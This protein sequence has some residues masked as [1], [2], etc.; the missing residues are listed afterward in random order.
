MA[1]SGR[2]GRLPAEAQDLSSTIASM[3]AQYENQRDRN[4]EFAWNHGGK[5]EG[6]KV[7][8]QF[9]INWWQQRRAEVSDDDPM[10]DYYDQ[11]IFNYRFQIREQ[12]VTLAYTQGKLN[13]AG[14]ARF[15]VEEAGKVPRNSAIWR[16]LMTNAAR[17]RKAAAKGRNSG[18]K[19]SSFESFQ[20][21]WN[22]L[23]DTYI[24]PAMTVESIVE[25][26]LTAT[27]T[28]S[29]SQWSQAMGGGEMS[30]V[31]D[32]F[33]KIENDPQYAQQ[34][35]DVWEPALRRADPH[36]FRGN[37]SNEYLA[38]VYGRARNGAKRQSKL[39][40]RRGYSDWKRSA[41]KSAGQWGGRQATQARWDLGTAVEQVWQDALD[42]GLNDQS[43]SPS[44]RMEI[45]AQ[46]LAEL[47]GLRRKAA[48][49]GADTLQGNITR[50]MRILRGDKAAENRSGFSSAVSGNIGDIPDSE[51]N[52]P[53]ARGGSEF[54][55]NMAEQARQD[56]KDNEALLA[57]ESV[58]LEE[59]GTDG[60]VRRT[61]VP[62]G[63]VSSGRG[64]AVEIIKA[65]GSSYRDNEGNEVATPSGA[66]TIVRI[67]QPIRVQV[68]SQENI[69][70]LE[71]QTGAGT[72]AESTS[73]V[74]G[75]LFTRADG[76]KQYQLFREDGTVEWT[77]AP[78]GGNGTEL[79]RPE[80][81][82][83]TTVGSDGTITITVRDTIG[84]TIVQ[85]GTDENGQPTYEGGERPRAALTDVARFG[86]EEVERREGKP[87]PDVAAGRALV[88]QITGLD[89]SEW[90]TQERA[91]FMALSPE[92]RR[93]LIDE[94]I[95][96]S[97]RTG[98]QGGG[99]F[100]RIKPTELTDARITDARD[101][102][103]APDR[104]F[105]G[106]KGPQ[107]TNAPIPA[108]PPDLAEVGVTEAQWTNMV[109]A[110][111]AGKQDAREVMNTYL[112]PEQKNRADQPGRVALGTLEGRL[113]EER[114]ATT[115]EP[116]A[117]RDRWVDPRTRIDELGRNIKALEDRLKDPNVAPQMSSGE[118]ERIQ[119][120]ITEM[121]QAQVRTGLGSRTTRQELAGQ[122]VSTATGVAQFLGTLL[123][124]NGLT[125]GTNRVTVEQPDTYTEYQTLVGGKDPASRKAMAELD[126][127]DIINGL[128]L[129]DP[130]IARDPE[131]LQRLNSEVLAIHRNAD[132]DNATYT[133]DRLQEEGV[134]PE[135][136]DTVA[137]NHPGGKRAP[138]VG[139]GSRGAPN[140]RGVGTSDDLMSADPS[141]PRTA[142]DEA[143]V[144][145]GPFLWGG[146]KGDPT[147]WGG[148]AAFS[149][150]NR[151]RDGDGVSPDA[152]DRPV[153][154]LPMIWGMSN[155]GSVNAQEAE[156]ERHRL[157]EQ[158]VMGSRVTFD[159]RGRKPV[160]PAQGSRVTPEPV[161]KT[162]KPPPEVEPPP[163][164]PK[165]TPAPTPAAKTATN[166]AIGAAVGGIRTARDYGGLSQFSIVNRGARRGRTTG[167]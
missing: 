26:I 143:D 36:H 22:N 48:E 144:P 97:G 85:T 44:E 102:G 147:Q 112:T 107:P 57:G 78:V 23:E 154:K 90:S 96:R 12:K 50:D 109:K 131:R 76:T 33:A 100:D 43:K 114:K 150:V 138:G 133:S 135:V 140:A 55:A 139:G 157:K 42:A 92:N 34:W 70:G 61:V 127:I 1:R 45:R 68:T 126:P 95:V 142:D 27:D 160:N 166:V 134:P 132:K 125:D 91:A 17:F 155:F 71:V 82:R 13:E 88:S 108:I 156:R 62:R 141:D 110:V 93:Y 152:G 74:V 115:Q 72:S 60:T 83:S 14:V 99:G 122:V 64:V 37:L 136:A 158:Q 21:Q 75:F 162:P 137:G 163:K 105:G 4:V 84:G 54:D 167:F 151:G 15:Y 40:D 148:L 79:I 118:K 103:N 19:Q 29:R 39:A 8:D 38:G 106:A 46:A 58:L 25:S 56:Q 35:R 3:I 165:P 59:V 89:T 77:D 66:I 161:M 69:T 101:H 117:Q 51:G 24:K 28:G 111:R 2:F 16:D 18:A 146:G 94:G 53:E 120:S 5:F 73:G 10:A 47:G 63:Q 130:S 124:R 7:T 123:G 11:M 49:L 41:D 87:P 6:K 81:V 153:M 9:F 67:G 113:N 32:L 20:T 80:L 159:P 30:M 98:Q 104:W 164:A 52:L 149:I 119:Q 86:E 129:A 65:N 121:R 116:V 145:I 31:E 128:M